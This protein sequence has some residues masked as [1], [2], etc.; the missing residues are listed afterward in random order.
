MT[1][2]DHKE[3]RRY[4]RAVADLM[5]LRDWTVQVDVGRP[6]S[7]DH[8]DGLEWGA[9]CAPVTGRKFAT[10]TFGP[11]LRH[12][13]VEELRQTVVHELVHCHTFGMWDSVRHDLLVPLGQQ[14]YDVFIAGFER[15]MENGVDA[16]ADA[17]APRM[18]LIEWSEP[19]K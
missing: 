17:I 1:K 12:V 16:L 9:S 4:V 11:Q 8:A 18:P 19:K 14:T 13:L 15:Q 10:L 7:P 2:R 5:E 3:L 6:N